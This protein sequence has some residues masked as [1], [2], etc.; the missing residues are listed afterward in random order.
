MALTRRKPLVLA[1]VLV[2]LVSVAGSAVA[3]DPGD[4]FTD[5][6]LWEDEPYAEAGYWLGH[7]GIFI[8]DEDGNLQPARP[9]TRAE[10]AVVLARMTGQESPA[11]SLMGSDTG[12]TDDEDIPYWASGF[13]ALA[14]RNGWFIG[15]EDGSVRPSAS[16]T[17]AETSILL[18]RV[19]GNEHLAVGEWP[20][21]ALVAARAMDLVGDMEEPGPN[22]PVLRGDMVF[23]TWTAVRIGT[24]DEETDE[25]DEEMS[26]L[27]LYHRDTHDAYKDI[28]RPP[29][30]PEWNPEKQALL[31]DREFDTNWT[32]IENWFP[33]LHRGISAIWLSWDPGPSMIT[34]PDDA[35]VSTMLGLSEGHPPGN[36]PMRLRCI[37]AKNLPD[38]VQ[39]DLIVRLY[40]GD[41]LIEE[42]IEEDIPA[43]WTIREYELS[44][45]P[46]NWDDLRVELTRQG[47]TTA[48]ESELRKVC[49][50][51]V[52][53][54]IPYPEDF[55]FPYLNPATTTQAP[56]SDTV[57]RPRGVK[58]GDL[59]FVSTING[60]AAEGFNLIHSQSSIEDA[61]P[62]YELHT[63][64]KR[65][66]ADEPDSY[67]F[68]HAEG[69]WAARI[70]G[71]SE[72]IAAA[73]H[74]EP[75]PDGFVSPVGI[76]TP[77]VDVP[78]ENSLILR[79]SANHGYITWTK[80]HQW[81]AWDEWPCVAASWRFQRE[82]GSTGEEYHDNINLTWHSQY[83]KSW[84]LK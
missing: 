23:A 38:G 33:A 49:V 31:P 2:F 26:L 62:P 72:P 76:N 58:E 13:M 75:P 12:W 11:V 51:L 34:S 59:V 16:L 53:M 61:H 7:A 78:V 10:M 84:I 30:A 70:S 68:P 50:S 41:T 74:V 18:A 44:S 37:F 36:G 32:M 48:P 55:T 80:P 79:I 73:S 71:A 6:S 14:E 69:I 28:P 21:S 42:W 57:E 17:W 25:W 4:F 8:G 56:G 20:E 35:N 60:E 46:H 9:L 47:E 15:Y 77:S 63:W 39:L 24:H 45:E 66:G 1:V 65:A 52:E 83:H 43:T 22:E 82:A 54:E 5:G 29:A 67:T 19:T 27:T 81:I 40:D 3:F 64:W